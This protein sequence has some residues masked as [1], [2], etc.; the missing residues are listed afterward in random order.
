MATN[1]EMLEE[2]RTM[3]AAYVK[4]EAIVLTGQ[5]Y[6]IKDRTLTRAIQMGA[7][8]F[9]LKRIDEPLLR[10][11]RLGLL[12]SLFEQLNAVADISRLGV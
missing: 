5:S 3:Y 8:G 7:S 6:S 2:A 12:K 10:A 1:A 4:A 9:L 11:N